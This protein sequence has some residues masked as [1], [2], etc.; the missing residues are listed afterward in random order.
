MKRTLTTA[1]LLAACAPSSGDDS[2]GPLPRV[3]PASV[4]LSAAGL[5]SVA[6]FLRQKVEEDAFPGGVLLVGR[7]GAVAYTATVYA[8]VLAS[9]GSPY[10]LNQL[11]AYTG[12]YLLAWNAVAANERAVANAL[13][14]GAGISGKSPIT[15][16][17]RFPLGAGIALPRR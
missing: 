3:E 1:V 10:L 13:A 9:F 8:T 2:G 15:L 11:T 4:G 14:A 5:D 12:T 16:G 6:T 7:R 17:E